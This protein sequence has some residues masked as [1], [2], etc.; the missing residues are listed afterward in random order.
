[1]LH[2]IA[3]FEIAVLIVLYIGLGIYYVLEVRAQRWK[4]PSRPIRLGLIVGL[5]FLL[6]VPPAIG[7]VTKIKNPPQTDAVAFSPDGHFLASGSEG[8]PTGPTTTYD[9]RTIRLWGVATGQELV[10][11]FEMDQVWALAFRPD[12]GMLV[13]ATSHR[14]V[15]F[16]MP[17]NPQPLDVNHPPLLLLGHQYI[18]HDIEVRSVAFSPDGRTLAAVSEQPPT[19]DLW[20]VA[21]GKYLRA[22]FSSSDVLSSVAFSPDGHTLAVASWDQTVTLWDAL[23]STQLYT[24]TLLRTLAVEPAFCQRFHL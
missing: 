4:L 8:L 5:L 12:G 2:W 18:D 21:T 7:A 10:F 17:S 11:P 16:D 19:L 23:H 20:D 22:L 15:V 14:V 1:M 13:A 9:Q 3:L 6:A 24:L